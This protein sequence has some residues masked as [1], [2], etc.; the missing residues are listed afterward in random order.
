MSLA[1]LVWLYITS[2]IKGIIS[3]GRA[4]VYLF[5]LVEFETDAKTVVDA[6]QWS[7]MDFTEFGTSVESCRQVLNS[8]R[9]FSIG[10]VKRLTNVAAHELARVARSFAN[11]AYFDNPPTCIEHLIMNEI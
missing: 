7:S 5:I 10:F 6:V 8:D 4:L 1:S 3:F 11:P 2:G 9:H